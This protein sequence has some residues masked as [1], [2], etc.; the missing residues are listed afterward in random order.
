MLNNFEG[1]HLNCLPECFHFTKF[2]EE[3]MKVADKYAGRN[4]QSISM[5]VFGN[6]N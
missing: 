3:F 1:L 6:I 5:I 4:Q 2:R